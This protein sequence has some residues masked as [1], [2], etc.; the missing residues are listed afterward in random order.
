LR[1]FGNGSRALRGWYASSVWAACRRA[2][3]GNSSIWR[4]F[5]GRTWRCAVVCG[6]QLESHRVLLSGID[7]R[8]GVGA[9][10]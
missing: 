2:Q 5:A 7:I 4:F 10:V 6:S 9:K 8:F 3:A 1:C